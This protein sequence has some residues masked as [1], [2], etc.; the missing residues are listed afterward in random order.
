MLELINYSLLYIII[1]N[2]CMFSQNARI[3]KIYVWG[4]F[5]YALSQAQEVMDVQLLICHQN[6]KLIK[7][8]LKHCIFLTTCYILIS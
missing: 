3:D 1:F 5:Y 4:F 2:V 8:F 6:F 7:R